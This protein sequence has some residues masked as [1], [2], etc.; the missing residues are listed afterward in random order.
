MHKE[1]VRWIAG[2]LLFALLALIPASDLLAES[3]YLGPDTCEKCHRAEVTVWERTKHYKA[4][5]K[6]HRTSKAKKIVKAIGEKRM[7]R[8]DTCNMCHY[9][10][11]TEGE[12]T[13]AAAGPSCE[14]CHGASSGWFEIHNDYGEGVTRET[15]SAEHKAERV[16]KASEAG[17]I[18]PSAAYDVAL[19]CF[20][21]HAMAQDGLSGDTIVKM[22]DAG[23]PIN[24]D[25][26]LVRYSQGSVRHRFYPP[27]MTK[28][29]KMTPPELA[30]LFVT[31]HAASL[32]V[33]VKALGLSDHPKYV[34]AQNARIDAA[35]K[36]LSAIQNSVPEADR[37]L[38]DPSE[39]NARSLV[40][41]ISDK[42]LSSQVGAMLPSNDSYK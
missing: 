11:V 12:K 34:A 20:S 26:E 42:D 7:K 18:W 13:K 15:E 27:Q 3:F 25:Y 35:K 14:S 19:N 23:H 40:A 41:A 36:A 10:M 21:C 8:S 2:F 37:L 39:A 32:V 38:Q 29:A 9:T 30:R 6:V 31:G 24:P 17:M 5:K 1:L 4:L 22:L 28:N 16:R 33:S